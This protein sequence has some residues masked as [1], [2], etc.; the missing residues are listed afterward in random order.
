MALEPTF[1]RCVSGGVLRN[2][3]GLHMP[4]PSPLPD[5]PLP[6]SLP[7]CLP[8]TWRDAPPLG[9]RY[10]LKTW[11]PPPHPQPSCGVPEL[12]PSR[13]ILSE[14]HPLPLPLPLPPVAWTIVGR[15]AGPE[16]VFTVLA[17]WHLGVT[18]L[19]A[20]GPGSQ[21][22]CSLHPTSELCWDKAF[23]SHWPLLLIRRLII[24]CSP[25]EALTRFLLRLQPVSLLPVCS[26]SLRS[27]V[28]KWGPRQEEVG[29][30]QAWKPE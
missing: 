1:S 20:V 15:E 23:H 11:P 3:L 16:E 22:P 18:S 5:G 21:R 19:D 9:F 17:I 7:L 28:R 29:K 27:L 25:L 12:R 8:A 14:P 24:L 26:S 6:A 4:P 10:F 30:R 2:S 13:G